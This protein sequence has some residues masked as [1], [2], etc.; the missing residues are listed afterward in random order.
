MTDQEVIASIEQS[1][2]DPPDDRE[3]LCPD[4]ERDDPDFDE[5]YDA[6]LCDRCAKVE[7]DSVREDEAM[8]RYYGEKYG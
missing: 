6:T 2:L 1:R 4:C 8:E 5:D 7:H 3:Q